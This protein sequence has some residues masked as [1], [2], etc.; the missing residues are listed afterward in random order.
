MHERVWVV[1]KDVSTSC[2]H[3]L[4]YFNFSF[5]SNLHDLVKLLRDGFDLVSTGNVW[6][7]C[8]PVQRKLFL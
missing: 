5:K 6:K 8:R 1:F 3:K 4:G 2:F 7:L